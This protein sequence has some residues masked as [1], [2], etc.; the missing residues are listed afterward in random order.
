MFTAKSFGRSSPDPFKLLV[1][2]SATDIISD[3]PLDADMVL[4]NPSIQVRIRLLISH[5]D[6]SYKLL[7]LDRSYRFRNICA[8]AF[9]VDDIA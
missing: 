7:A 4:L 6:G 3:T 5:L 8:D 1:L 2:M 9:L